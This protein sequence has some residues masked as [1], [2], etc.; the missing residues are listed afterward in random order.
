M[1]DLALHTDA[2]AGP[3]SL[4]SIAARQSISEEYLEQI[5]STLR[6]SGLVESVRGAQGG[7]RLGRSADKI[8]VGEILRSLEGSLAPVDCVT[9]GRTTNDCVKYEECVMREVW[10]RMR[11]SLNQTVDSITLEDLAHRY[12]Q[13]NNNAEFMYYI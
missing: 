1:L 5:F 6:K 4:N 10:E 7:Y 8:T 12:R 9:E 3:V 11:D 13:K 2:A